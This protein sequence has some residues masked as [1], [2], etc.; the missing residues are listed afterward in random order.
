MTEEEP[1]HLLKEGSRQW[2]MSCSGP[3]T[4]SEEPQGSCK[5]ESDRWVEKS[6]KLEYVHV[7]Q[8]LSEGQILTRCKNWC[9]FFCG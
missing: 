2:G 7:D 6:G 5:Q 3:L 8:C 1:P 9:R 4:T